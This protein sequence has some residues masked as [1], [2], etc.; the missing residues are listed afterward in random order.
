MIFYGIDNQEVEIRIINYEYPPTGFGYNNTYHG[1]YEDFLEIEVRIISNYG[2]YSHN[3][4]IFMIYELQNLIN[5][6][7]KLSKNKFIENKYFTV[8][9]YFAFELLNKYNEKEKRFKILFREGKWNYV[10]CIADNKRLSK[11][12]KELSSELYFLFKTYK[13]I[14]KLYEIINKDIKEINKG[15]VIDKNHIVKIKENFKKGYRDE[16]GYKIIYTKS[17]INDLGYI[18][19]HEKIKNNI[20]AIYTQIEDIKLYPFKYTS[21]WD[22]YFMS[23]NIKF[24]ITDKYIIFYIAWR[25]ESINFIRIIKNNK[26]YNNYCKY[27]FRDLS[28]EE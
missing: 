21:K 16:K 7:E 24:K 19:K 13:T 10:E 26:Y 14:K 1:E 15:K 8:E 4:S 23:H 28:L 25:Y 27:D 18:E 9:D 20:Q 2:N 17:F 5:W 11:Y 12:V 3:S 6:L 22:N